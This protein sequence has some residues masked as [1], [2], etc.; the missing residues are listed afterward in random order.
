MITIYTPEEILKLREGGRRLAVVLREVEGRVRPGISTKELDLIAEE[1]IRA[2]GD[3]PAFLGYTP[4]GSEFP[5]PATLCT[6]VN[7]EVV[8]GIP[9]RENVLKE[10]D[11]IGLDIGLRHEGMIVDMAVTVAVGEI[12]SRAKKLISVTREALAA[13]IAA[14]VPLGHVGDIG[15]VIASYAAKEG[16]GVPRELGG[17]GVGHHVHEEPHI[18]NFKLSVGPKLRPGMVLALEPIFNEGG[19]AIVLADDGYTFLTKD[20]KRSAHFEHTIVVTE[21]GAEILTKEIKD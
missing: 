9:Q 17:H 13:G 11:I 5:Y 14:V 7:E 12:D 16:Y 19:R 1:L 2:G 8:H 15:A 3:Q 6:S 4:E 10:G 20:G 21:T 18:A